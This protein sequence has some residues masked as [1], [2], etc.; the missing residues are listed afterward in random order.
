MVFAPKRQS[1]RLARRGG[2]TWLER[3]NVPDYKYS[4]LHTA[5]KQSRVEG[6]G[7]AQ[8]EKGVSKVRPGTFER[9]VS[10]GIAH[11]T[12]YVP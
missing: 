11:R 5:K 2:E 8:L 9:L 10:G 3:G 12:I 6:E 1:P 4:E 7:V